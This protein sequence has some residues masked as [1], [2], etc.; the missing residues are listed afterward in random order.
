MVIGICIERKFRR[1]KVTLIGRGIM[2]SN[3]E[4][5]NEDEVGITKIGIKILNKRLKANVEKLNCIVNFVN[6]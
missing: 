3:V 1:I 2:K 4:D 5:V 6:T